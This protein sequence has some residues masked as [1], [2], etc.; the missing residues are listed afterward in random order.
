MVPLWESGPREVFITT[1]GCCSYASA[2]WL[3]LSRDQGRAPPQ[4]GG[5]MATDIA[6]SIP[7]GPAGV[8]LSLLRGGVPSRW[9][10]CNNSAVPSSTK[11]LLWS[12]PSIISL[13]ATVGAVEHFRSRYEAFRPY[14]LVATSFFAESSDPKASLWT[15]SICNCPNK[16]GLPVGLTVFRPV[17]CGTRHPV[18]VWTVAADLGSQSMLAWFHH[19]R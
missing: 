17:P 2:S 7:A 18:D 12:C 5:I 8:S 19:P 9:T 4:S 1:T 15:G 13:R 16:L 10:P 14:C 11:L 6:P 3:L